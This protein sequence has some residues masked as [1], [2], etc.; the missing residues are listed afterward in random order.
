MSNKGLLHVID[1]EIQWLTIAERAIYKT[2]ARKCLISRVCSYPAKEI[3]KQVGCTTRTVSRA[4]EVL[5][6]CLAINVERAP[7]KKWSI[8]LGE[9][10]NSRECYGLDLTQFDRSYFQKIVEIDARRKSPTPDILSKTHDIVSP[11][12]PTFCPKTP[13]TMSGHKSIERILKGIESPNRFPSLHYSSTRFDAQEFKNSIETLVA[14]M[15]ESA[16][17]FQGTPL[18]SESKSTTCCPPGEIL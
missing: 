3:A 13:D 17:Y 12:P 11:L 5:E 7:G 15:P 16:K 10:W 9:L 6:A 2:I 8:T 18:P 1:Q 14:R 4:L